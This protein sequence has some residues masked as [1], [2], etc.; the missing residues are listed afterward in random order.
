MD[1]I[2]LHR[3]DYYGDWTQMIKQFEVGKIY[4]EFELTE[5]AKGPRASKCARITETEFN[6]KD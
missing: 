1:N 6:L 2:F 5:G 3:N 4:V